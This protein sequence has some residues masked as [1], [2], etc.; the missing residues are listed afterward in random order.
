M[1][2]HLGHISFSQCTCYIVRGGALGIHWAGGQPMSLHCGTVCR[3]R[4]QRGNI[5]T[6]AA[7]SQLS[8]TSPTTHKQIGAFLCWF[9]SGWFCVH[10]KTLWV[11]PM[12]S[13]VRLRVSPTA[14]TPTGFKSQRFWGFISPC[15]NSGL[16]G[17]THYPVVP[18]GLSAWKM[19]GGPVHQP[20]PHL[21]GPP[22][23]ALSH[24]LSILA[25][26][27]CPSYL[28]GWIFLL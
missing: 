11:S 1:F 8:D 18:P 7:L 19:W 16:H 2:F 4:G 28:S 23:T 17:L 12:D 25:A 3:G 6:C 27:L 20:Q 21:L 14:A 5:A 24:I 15:W 22:A 10:S 9:P 13:P 26:R